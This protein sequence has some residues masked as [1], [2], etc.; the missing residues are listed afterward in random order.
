[1]GADAKTSM[2]GVELTDA[3]AARITK[4]LAKEPG[5]MHV[6]LV[7]E[8]ADRVARIADRL[9]ATPEEAA[10]L[11]EQTD[12]ERS[13]YLKHHFGSEWHDPH[14]FHLTINTSLVAVERAALLV[15]KL[16]RE[17]SH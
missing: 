11:V 3:A 13:A 15:E 4:I 8:R 16:I 1:M 7:A 12:R 10:K 5:V 17:E 14:H 6:R 2:K 9:S